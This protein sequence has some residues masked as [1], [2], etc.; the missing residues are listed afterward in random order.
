MLIMKEKIKL[1]LRK[2]RKKIVEYI[3]TN[4][5]FISYVIISLLGLALIRNFTIGNMFSFKTFIVDVAIVI[6][7][8]SL[9]YLIKPQNQFRYFFIL[10][11]IFCFPRGT[12]DR[13]ANR[14][15]DG[16]HF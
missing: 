6:M 2:I 5:L 15:C 4:R 1:S 12:C 9:G 16:F 14:N 3:A 8:G 10:I 7:I 11:I 13:R